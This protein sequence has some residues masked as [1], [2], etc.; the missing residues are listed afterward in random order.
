MQASSASDIPCKGCVFRSLLR[1]LC[2]VRCI[3]VQLVA[4][5]VLPTLVCLTARC[6]VQSVLNGFDLEPCK[7]LLGY[8]RSGQTQ[9]RRLVVLCG[10]G[11]ER[12]VSTRSMLLVERTWSSNSAMRIIKYV[13]KG[14]TP[15]LPG[16]NRPHAW[17]RLEAQTPADVSAQYQQ[18]NPDAL[19]SSAQGFQVV[20]VLEEVLLQARQ[21]NPTVDIVREAR[22]AL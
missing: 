13:A 4:T 18:G 15:W 20:L 9:R 22:A 3:R 6:G 1:A 19:L 12:S 5:G 8:V 10:R 14:F 11:F 2:L 17:Q 21:T 16:L 7:V